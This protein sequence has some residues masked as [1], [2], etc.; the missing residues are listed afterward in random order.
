M[1]Y[2]NH[3]DRLKYLREWYM[4][5]RDRLLQKH[6]MWRINHKDQVKASQ[7][8]WIKNNQDKVKLAIK[9]RNNSPES[10]IYKR[11][12]LE[13]NRV[14]YRIRRREREHKQRMRIIELFGGKCVRCGFS[15][16]RALQVDHINGGGNKE[17]ESFNRCAYLKHIENLSEEERKSKYQLLCANCNYIKRFEN[18]EWGNY[19]KEALT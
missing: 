1:P 15:D 10:K 18:K 9:R 5:N 17:R 16:W 14:Q 13:N 12:H 7:E 2:K 3:E 11:K 19:E 6:R 8:K 4:L